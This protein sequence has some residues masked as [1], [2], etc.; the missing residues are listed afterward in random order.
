M[1]TAIGR[2]SS[3][4]PAPLLVSFSQVARNTSTP[5]PTGR[6]NVSADATWRARLRPISLSALVTSEDD[7]LRLLLEKL[8]RHLA[9]VAR[10]SVNSTSP[11]AAESG[12][13]RP[14]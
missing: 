1:N 4:R 12:P 5:R 6:T 13:Q 3:D 14:P 10:A 11:S 8:C 2:L 7:A 9:T